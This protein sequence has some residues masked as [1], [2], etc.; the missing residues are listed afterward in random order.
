MRGHATAS[1]PSR[2]G[3]VQGPAVIIGAWRLPWAARDRRPRLRHGLPDRPAHELD[4]ASRRL[5]RVRD[6]GPRRAVPGRRRA[7]DALRRRAGGRS[8]SRAAPGPPRP[9]AA[10]RP[11]ELPRALRRRHAGL[12]ARRARRLGHRPLGRAR[13][14]RAPRALAAR[15]AREPRA[16][17]GLVRSPRARRGL[18]RAPHADRAL[19]HLDPGRNARESARPRTPCS[20]S[21]DRPSGASALPASDGRWGPATSRSTTPSAMSTSW[22]SQA[23]WPC[24][25]AC[26]CSAEGARGRDARGPRCD[27]RGPRG[28]SFHGLRIAPGDVASPR[29]LGAG[30]LARAGR[31]APARDRRRRPARRPLAR[32]TRAGAAAGTR[33]R[34]DVGP[35]RRRPG[36]RRQL[37]G[38]RRARGARVAAARRRAADGG[39]RRGRHHAGLEPLRLRRRQRQRTDGG[40]HAG[41]GR[42]GARGPPGACRWRCRTRRR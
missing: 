12:P 37:G 21:R 11:G 39:P 9:R 33:A 40:D 17:R 2:S 7:D 5:R 36:R 25:S 18:P 42:A 24:S 26:S 13:A 22:P 32:P 35:R 41:R 31:R 20:R 8:H 29:G 6:H 34:G 27:R 10:D 3:P 14:A 28:D 19:V 38:R 16:R 1:A 23:P 15:D 30:G 4:R